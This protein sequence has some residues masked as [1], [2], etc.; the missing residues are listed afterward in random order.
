[1]SL[2]AF[3]QQKGFIEKDKDEAKKEN[4]TTTTPGQVAPTYFPVDDPG[5]PVTAP[6]NPH[7][8]MNHLI[9]HS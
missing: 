1:M 4:V 5:S 7:Q 8:V 9:L 2:K 3:L 6:R